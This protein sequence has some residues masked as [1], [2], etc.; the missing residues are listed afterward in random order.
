MTDYTNII[1]KIIE[2]EEENFG[3][4]ALEHAKKVEGVNIDENGEVN[5]SNEDH[6]QILLDLI[7]AYHCLV[8]EAVSEA[9]E[10][11]EINDSELIENLQPYFQRN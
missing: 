11:E 5:L 1:Q 9:L 4:V 8:G 3:P 6:E 2:T 7:Q 10:E